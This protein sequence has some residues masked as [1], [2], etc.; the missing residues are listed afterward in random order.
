[1][2]WDYVAKVACEAGDSPT[3][4]KTF[5]NLT[6][7]LPFEVKVDVADLEVLLN[8]REDHLVRGHVPP[9]G[10]IL[11]GYADVQMRG[12]WLEIIAHAPT[13]EKWVVDAMYIDGDTSDPNGE[14]F[15]TLIRETV[16]REFPDAFGSMRKLDALGIDSGYRAHVVYAKVRASQRLHPLTGR[17]VIL[18][19]K[20]LQG[21][22][23]PPLGQ[24]VLVD[25][26]LSGKR[27]KQGVKVWG[28]GTWPLKAAHYTDLKIERPKGQHDYPP[29]Y[30]HH[31]KWLDEVY[32]KQLTAE[33]LQKFK[34][35]VG[36]TGTRWVP[37]GPN[38]F[39]DCRVGNLALA[40]YLG[41]SSTTP[42]EWATLATMRGLPPEL[43]TADLFTPARSKNVVE[44]AKA[45]D[46]IAARKV[47]DRSAPQ[48]LSEAA[49]GWLD[50]YEVNI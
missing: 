21:W 39:L 12:L 38:H 22:G 36:T 13:R 25:I 26:N 9:Q 35:R 48:E 11:T 2:P 17:D 5:Y 16:D 15:Q 8:R 44:I 40:E 4:L 30:C 46:A 29:G 24:P 20:G 32:F 49:R 41:L 6:L 31:G 3:K 33:S 28:I 43:S 19:T 50:G 45:D 34:T 42:Q 27:I 10:L 23:R 18:A 47:A 37:H 1:M 14:A 7:G